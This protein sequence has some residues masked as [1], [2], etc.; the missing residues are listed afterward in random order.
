M[1]PMSA[2]ESPVA[3]GMDGGQAV[4]L[5]AE[6]EPN[7]PRG[8]RYLKWT[9]AAAASDAGIDRRFP[10]DAGRCACVLGTT[11]H[12]MRGAGRFFADRRFCRVAGFL[13][14]D[15]LATAFKDATFA[16]L[17]ATVCSACSSSLGSIALG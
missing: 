15:V 7:L 16:G 2:L 8:G 1:R 17:A 13:A 4:D 14:G 12:G 10:C 11:L 9:L 3:P 6:F 5:P